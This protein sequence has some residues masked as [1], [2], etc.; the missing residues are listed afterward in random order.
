MKTRS[1]LLENKKIDALAEKVDFKAN[2]CEKNVSNKITQQKGHSIC[3][4]LVVLS[5]K[6]NSIGH[7]PTTKLSYRVISLKR[8]LF[9]DY[10]QRW[11]GR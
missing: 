9:V 6:I 10:T 2:L 1:A 4:M 8:V 3:M 11:H 5:S 7:R